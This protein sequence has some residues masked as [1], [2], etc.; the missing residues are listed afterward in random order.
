[1]PRRLQTRPVHVERTLAKADRQKL[2]AESR[3]A[4]SGSGTQ[5]ELLEALESGRLPRHPGD[6]VARHPRARPREG[7]ATRSAGTRYVAPSRTVRRPIPARRSLTLLA[8][9]GRRAAT[10]AQNIVVVQC[11]DRLGP[12]D[13]PGARS[14]ASIQLV[15]RDARRR[16]H[17]V[18]SSRWTRRSARVLADEL[19]RRGELDRQSPP[20]DAPP[21]AAPRAGRAALRPPAGRSAAR[22]RAARRRRRTARIAAGWP[23]TLTSGVNGVNSPPRWNCSHGSS[24]SKTQPI[25]TGSF[26]SAGVSTTSTSLQNATTCRAVSLQRRRPLARRSTLDVSHARAACECPVDRLQ[27]RRGSRP[28]YS[29]GVDLPQLRERA[30]AAT[31]PTTAASPRRRRARARRARRLRR[32]RRPRHA[33]STSIGIGGSVVNAM[34]SRPGSAPTSSR[35][36]RSG[37]GA[38]CASPG[39]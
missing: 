23:V 4:G 29:A 33:R 22:R 8:Q 21:R 38:Q 35:N 14:G 37:A 36:G 30:R 31:R 34:R 13:R 28:G 24:G 5:Q 17:A 1:M 10:A 9:F 18:S 27:Q 12:R 39:S 11:R 19:W 26:A 25:G 32:V 3:R 15:A 2:V 7:N 16:R 6:R 20:T